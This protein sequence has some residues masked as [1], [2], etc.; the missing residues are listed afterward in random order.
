LQP[1]K[2]WRLLSILAGGGLDGSLEGL[3]LAVEPEGRS[4]HLHGRLELGSS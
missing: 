3:S 1:W 2:P 4:L